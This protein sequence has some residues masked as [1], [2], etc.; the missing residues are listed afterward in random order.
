MSGT[1]ENPLLRLA[2]EEIIGLRPYAHAAWEPSLRRLHANE[3]PWRPEG[4]QTLAGLNRYPEPQP[5]A[6]I[7]RLAGLYGVPATHVLA[8]RGSDEAIDILSRLYLRAGQDAILQ[9]G[10]AHV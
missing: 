10:R 8:T 1:A 6:L 7:A 3:V 2:R 5:A 4:D 9:I